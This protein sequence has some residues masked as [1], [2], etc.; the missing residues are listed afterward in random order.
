ML[1]KQSISRQHSDRSGLTSLTSQTSFLLNSVALFSTFN[2]NNAQQ[3]HC[4]LKDRKM[5]VSMASH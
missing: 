2:C 1:V 3:I 5:L 4:V